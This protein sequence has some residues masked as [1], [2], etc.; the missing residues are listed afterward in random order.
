MHFTS[1]FK[2]IYLS[3][4][5]SIIYQLSIYLLIFIYLLFLFF[6]DK[7]SLYSPASKILGLKV[8]ATTA[9]HIYLSIYHLPIVYLALYRLSIYY[10]FIIYYLSIYL[11]IYLSSICLVKYSCSPRWHQTHSVAKTGFEFSCLHSPSYGIPRAHHHTQPKPLIFYFIRVI[12]ICVCVYL[13]VCMCTS[14]EG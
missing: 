13:H 9:Q 7:V 1:P 6:Q 14:E 11:S 5:L 10:L 3:I 12:L 2:N 4:Y 8:C